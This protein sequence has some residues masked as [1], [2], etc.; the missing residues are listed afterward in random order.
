MYRLS[1]YDK[2]WVIF[3]EQ[4]NKRV[5]I[6]INT[7]FHSELSRIIFSTCWH[8]LLVDPMCEMFYRKIQPMY[9]P[10]VQYYNLLKYLHR[11]MCSLVSSKNI[12]HLLRGLC[13]RCFLHTQILR[14]SAHPPRAAGQ[15]QA[16]SACLPPPAA[17]SAARN[18]N[19]KYKLLLQ[20]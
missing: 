17:P 9:N 16:P 12:L 11:R 1:K 7:I 8:L 14:V 4:A 10:Y 15:T 20:N 2:V 6:S 13:M 3:R 19:F 5:F 18:G